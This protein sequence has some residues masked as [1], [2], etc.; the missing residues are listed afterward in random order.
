MTVWRAYPEH[1]TSFDMSQKVTPSHSQHFRPAATAL[2]RI[3]PGRQHI[4]PDLDSFRSGPLYPAIEDGSFEMTRKCCGHGL[5]SL[6]CSV[7]T[8]DPIRI[9]IL[10]ECSD[11]ETC[12]VRLQILGDG[13]DPGIVNPTAHPDTNVQQSPHHV[14]TPASAVAVI[15]CACPAKTGTTSASSVERLVFSLSEVA[16]MTGFFRTRDRA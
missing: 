2:A 12:D 8:P 9:F 14:V 11:G 16:R 13:R 5:R 1:H 3:S 4:F 6:W 15:R 10:C 7:M